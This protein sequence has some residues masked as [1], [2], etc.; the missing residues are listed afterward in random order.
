MIERH[1]ARAFW[2]AAPFR[3]IGALTIAI[4]L[5]AAGCADG[6]I[7]GQ[8][9]TTTP[10]G[11]GGTTPPGTGGLGGSILPPIG[12]V[13]FN[14]EPT[15]LR[16]LTVPQY[17]NSVRDLFGDTMTV[18]TTFEQDTPLSGF[19]SIGAA[20]VGLSSAL[21][22]QFEVASLEVA[23]KV[24]TGANRATLVGCMPTAATDDACT[25]A[26]VQKVGRRVW[27]R[28]LTDE[29]TTRY[30]GVAKNAQT[31]LNNFFGGLEYGLAGLLQSPYFLYRQEIGTVDPK[32]A[33]R[34][35]FSEHELATRLSF[36]LWN[37]TPDDQLLDAADARTL[38]GG[39]LVTHAQRLLTSP[40]ISAGM[41]SFFAE[42][43][44]LK[45]LDDLPQSPAIFPLMSATMGASMR[46]ETLRFLNEI[47]FV[48]D[49]DYR[50]IFDSRS[51]FVN[52]ELAKVYGITGVTGTAMTAA[53]LPDAGVRAGL[54]GQGSF[55]AIHSAPNR[56]SPTK[57]GKFIREMILCGEVPAAPPDIEPFPEGLTG[58]AKDKLT[59]HRDMAACRSCH[60]A[61]D[62]IGLGL[63]NFDG[64]GVMRTMDGG[65]MID[66]SGD[67]DGTP[68]A[69]PRELATVLKNHPDSLSC[70]AKN[71]YRYALAHVEGAGEAGSINALVKAFQDDGFRFRAL[72]EGVVKSPAFYVAAKAP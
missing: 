9:S 62:P 25:R 4:G 35:V 46:A 52:A 17:Q 69:G 71:V 20:R 56:S 12:D 33:N 40:K 31:V 7:G 34:V 14:P 27:R 38:A 59:A 26:F 48:K 19:A 23:K 42:F 68:F 61:M 37:S 6:T 39:G 36:F 8:G 43:Y 5:G 70:V 41:Q 63:E 2:R 67:V 72:L 22:E 65:K 53:T 24:L 13:P 1:Q 44:R 60:A 64:L 58:T 54:I 66:P 47:A 50:D 57:R 30:F 28:P 3:T 16:R 32:N 55:L 51:T 45:E 29:E 49:G 15:G 11:V 21:T 10:S 18:A